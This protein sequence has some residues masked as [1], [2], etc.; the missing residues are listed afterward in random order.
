M[1]SLVMRLALGR[2][3]GREDVCRAV[4]LDDEAGRQPAS[5]VGWFV[6]ELSAWMVKL[7][8]VSLDG[9]AGGEAVRFVCWLV[10]SRMVRLVVRLVVRLSAWSFGW[11]SSCQLGW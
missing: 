6:V 2:P 10:R 1:N 8:V 9:K 7:L 5:L 11:W 3:T 4:S